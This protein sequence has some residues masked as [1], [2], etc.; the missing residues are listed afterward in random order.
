MGE[1][2]VIQHCTN[3]FQSIRLFNGLLPPSFDQRKKAETKYLHTLASNAIGVPVH[4]Q[5]ACMPNWNIISIIL[6]FLPVM[7]FFKTKFYF[8]SLPLYTHCLFPKTVGGGPP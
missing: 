8:R 7:H 1:K 4:L 3:D 6:T 2:L 5:P